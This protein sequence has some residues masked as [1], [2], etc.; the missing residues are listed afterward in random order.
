MGSRGVAFST[1]G[2]KATYPEIT[3]DASGGIIAWQDSRNASSDIYASGVSSSGVLPVKLISFNA[4][5]E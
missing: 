5:I 2:G 3:G 4:M 1:V